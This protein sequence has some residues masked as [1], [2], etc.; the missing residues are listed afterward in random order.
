MPGV[1]KTDAYNRTVVAFI[2]DGLV[3]GEGSSQD[4]G[5][6]VSVPWV[7]NPGST[8]RG[9]LIYRANIVAADSGSRVL[10]SGTLRAID[11]EGISQRVSGSRT[12][13]MST[14]E[15]ITSKWR[16]KNA[17]HQY[18]WDRLERLA[19]AIQAR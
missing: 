9:E 2:A 18:G 14:A 5:L 3:I 12:G 17:K 13:Q 7:W 11:S 15:P 1:S 10:L 8:S 19:N 16:S 6:V 4:A